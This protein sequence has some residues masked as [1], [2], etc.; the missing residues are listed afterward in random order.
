MTKTLY[1]VCHDR[2]P[3]EQPLICI[4]TAAESL[5]EAVVI[6]AFRQAL[7]GF[8]PGSED[9]PPMRYAADSV[10]ARYGVVVAFVEADDVFTLPTESRCSQCGRMAGRPDDD[11]L[12]V[13][14]DGFSDQYSACTICHDSMRDSYEHTSCESCGAYFTYNHLVPNK[15]DDEDTRE[16]CPYCGSIW[17]E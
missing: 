5:D 2:Q 17:C 16:I 6:T 15:D 4:I 14:N 10:S 11:G 8:A 7:Q 12:V 1:F 9:C 3:N 13:I